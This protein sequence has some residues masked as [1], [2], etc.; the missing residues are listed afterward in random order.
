MN[1]K[2]LASLDAV[3]GFDMLFIMG[4]EG[5]VCAVAALFGFPEFGKTFGH[6]PWH[7][8]HFMDLVFPT[9]LF[10]AGASFPF[11]AA[12]SAA[13]GLSRGKVALRALRRGL[14]LFALG[15]VYGGLLANFNFSDFRVW[16]VL[17]RIGL[18]WMFAAWI[19]LYVRDA[20]ARIGVTAGLLAATTLVT[21][22]VLAPGAPA[23]ADPFS[24]EWN[25]GCW[26][27]RTL[28]AGH[29]YPWAGSGVKEWAG[30]KLFDPE[31]FA[32]LVPAIAT[33]LLGMFAGDLVRRGD[34]AATNRKTGQLFLYA[35]V[36]ALAGW[37]LSFVF[38]VNKAL[39][40]PSFAL[41][42]GGISC[43]AFATFY[44]L[45]DVKGWTKWSF[46]F[47][48]IGMNSITIYLAQ[49]VI[50]FGHARD[51]LFKGLAGCFPASVGAV[52]MQLGYIATCWAFLYFLYRK[53]VFLKV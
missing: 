49:T 11:S 25:L 8:L 36:C 2:R 16:S 37:A 30:R 19:Y 28:T 51:F 22:F 12:A 14:T 6:V 38:P 24:P 4:G 35:L 13:R 5:L 15:V 7:G 33:A 20:R 9:F 21:L 42:V 34:G 27:D 47:R 39:W 18:A 41:V 23:G 46:F 50:G 32:G 26:L 43:A 48:V 40:S 52:V 45:V 17:G 44:W 10:L 53:N 29:T 1:G 31:G 3:R